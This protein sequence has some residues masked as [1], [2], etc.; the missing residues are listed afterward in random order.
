V[1]FDHDFLL[2]FVK[3]PNVS[4]DSF[5]LEFWGVQDLRSYIRRE[6]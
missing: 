3:V 1:S 2:S 4:H 6:E 5:P